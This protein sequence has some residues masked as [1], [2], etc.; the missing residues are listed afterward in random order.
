M[1]IRVRMDKKRLKIA[2]FIINPYFQFICIINHLLISKKMPQMRAGNKEPS[3]NNTTN[4]TNAKYRRTKNLVK[5]TIEISNQCDLDFILLVYDK[6]FN[7]FREIY[8]NPELT[9]E[10]VDGMMKGTVVANRPAGAA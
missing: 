1:V 6:K 2:V 7:R 3:S 4:L 8:T 9:L 10:Q 5:K